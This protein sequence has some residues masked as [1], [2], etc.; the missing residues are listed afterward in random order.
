MKKTLLTVCIAFM[1]ANLNAQTIQDG[2]NHLYADRF[3]NAEQTFQ[4]LLAANPNT[5]EATY[6]LGQTYLDMDN[7]E[8]ARQLYEKALAANGNNPIIMVGKGHV[9]LLDKKKDEARQLFESAITQSTTKKGED[10]IVLN[11]I[12]R[13]NVDAKEGNPVYAVQVLERAFQREPKN[14]DI[15]LNLGNA[16]RKRDIGIGGKSY[17]MYK[18]ATELNPR[19]AYP[20]V[21]IAKIY[22]TQRQW[23]L[24]LENLNKALQVDPNFS[25]AYYELFFYYFFAKQDYATAEQMLQKYVNSRPNEDQWEH[26]YLAAQL[27]WARKNYDCAITKAEAVKATMGNKVKPRILKL[28]A[29]S[30][31]GKNDFTTA[32][33]YVDEFFAKEKDGFVGPDY[34]LKVDIYGGAGVPC[35]VLYGVYLEG[36]AADTVLQSKIDYLAKAADYFKSK[37]CKLQEADMRMVWFNTRGNASPTY[38]VN[39]GILYTQ[40]DALLKAD[41]IFQ[42]YIS[43]AADS[44]YGYSWRGR[45]NYS[46]DT[47]M[48]VEPYVT[49][50]VTSYD[51][52]LTI[53]ATDP[54]RYKTHGVTAAKTLAAYYVNIR[55]SRDTALA[56]AYKGL[57]IDSTDPGLKNIRD[58]LEKS[59]NQ[60]PAG[61]TT[62]SKPSAAIRKPA[63]KS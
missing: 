28:L 31:L 29:Y 23:D 40:A 6:W 18:L 3:K 10:P 7:N 38:L 60:K 26:D 34:Q 49:N 37:N 32:K 12:G 52:A 21:R 55:A 2:I 41:S 62:G 1:L 58:I 50:M 42:R 19:F 54:V 61:K 15:A 24:V 25:L 14:T 4:K 35:D 59:K 5:A 17:E 20:W 9:L 46:L 30:Y 56:Y 27:C 39:F 13:A 33:N 45:V 43:L 44:I 36:A 22:E 8:A 63:E 53:A 51:K 57:A 47:T 48:L 16:Y 11:A